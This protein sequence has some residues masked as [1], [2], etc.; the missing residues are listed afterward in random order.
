MKKA[1][2]S[3]TIYSYGTL[4]TAIQYGDVGKADAGARRHLWV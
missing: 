2:R 1:Y 3:S 4:A